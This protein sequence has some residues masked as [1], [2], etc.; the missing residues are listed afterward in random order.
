MTRIVRTVRRGIRRNSKTRGT[1]GRRWPFARVGDIVRCGRSIVVRTKRFTVRRVPAFGRR[2]LV[3]VELRRSFPKSVGYLIAYCC[4]TY[5]RCR[6]N[7]GRGHRE[8]PYTLFNET[9]RRRK[10]RR[11]E[12]RSVCATF[13]AFSL[14]IANGTALAVHAFTSKIRL[15]RVR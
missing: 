10:W 14:S 1:I 5:T 12:N 11:T 8:R 7:S 3:L 6:D 15:G 4:R 9:E 13:V 2:I